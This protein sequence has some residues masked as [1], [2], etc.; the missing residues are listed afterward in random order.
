MGKQPVWTSFQEAWLWTEIGKGAALERRPGERV[1]KMIVWMLVRMAQQ[2]KRFEK[3][4]EGD[5]QA[6][7][8]KAPE[9]REGLAFVG[10]EGLFLVKWQG[11]A[12]ACRV[13]ILIW[14][15]WFSPNRKDRPLRVRRGRWVLREGRR[16]IVVTESGRGTD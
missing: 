4:E 5:D 1:L 16:N 9:S 12:M 6:V 3:Q 8:E 7:T 10:R 13:W 11:R 2:G 15:L 14:C